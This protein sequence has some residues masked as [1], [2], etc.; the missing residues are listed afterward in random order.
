MPT[1]T[2]RKFL[3]KNDSWRKQAVS[4]T[5]IRQAYAHFQNDSRMTLRI[6]LTDDQAY[7]T[8]KGPVRGCSR[9]EFEYPLPPQD[10]QEIL[11]EFCE[12]GRIEKYRYRIPIGSHVWEV[13]EFLGNNAGLTMAEI[14]LDSPDEPFERPEWLGR[15]VTGEVR[16]YNSHLLEYPFRD[17]KGKDRE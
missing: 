12:S 17:W 6:R 1:E 9:S 11:E 5:L 16:F 7:L 13:D 14:E 4:C 2:E 10:A 3:L 15:E 8:L